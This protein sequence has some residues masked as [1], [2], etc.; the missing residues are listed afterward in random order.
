MFSR[1][2]K[3]EDLNAQCRF[4]K[5]IRY[6]FLER[7]DKPV[8]KPKI[9]QQMRYR[10]SLIKYADKHG[11]TKA[12]RVYNTSRQNIYR[13]KKR[14]DGDIRSLANLSRR[15]KSHPNQHTEDEIKLIKDMLKKNKDTG[16]VIFLGKIKRTRI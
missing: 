9:T 1:H 2:K 16:L 5:P 15:P 6:K 3:Q 14:Y 7:K 12:S 13:Y 4:V 10:L 8:S 11:V